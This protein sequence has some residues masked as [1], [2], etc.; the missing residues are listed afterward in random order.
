MQNNNT[1]DLSETID[2][3]PPF[4]TTE[5]WASMVA[6]WTKEEWQK[7]SMIASKNHQ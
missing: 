5:K 4:T 1:E 7:K 3:R 6:K 2:K